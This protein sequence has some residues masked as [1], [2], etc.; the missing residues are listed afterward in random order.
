[1]R[2]PAR[3]AL[4][5][6]PR[7]RTQCG[8]TAMRAVDIMTTSVVTVDPDMPIKLVAKLLAERRISGVPVVDDELHVVGM[9]SE[10]DLLRRAEIGT[11]RRGSW[12]L[13]LLASNRELA[14]AYVK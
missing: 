4:I 5:S 6:G 11:A 9:I 1:M 12:W 14:D 8:E 7:A 2:C 10:G 13:D 3:S